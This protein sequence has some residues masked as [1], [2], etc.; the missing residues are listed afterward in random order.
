MLAASAVL[1]WI[2]R[3]YLLDRG[4]FEKRP[5]TPTAS[6]KNWVGVP[7]RGERTAGLCGKEHGI[8]SAVSGS[9]FQTRPMQS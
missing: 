2:N 8:Y 7:D 1:L 4:N 9:S 5:P 3:Q 6:L